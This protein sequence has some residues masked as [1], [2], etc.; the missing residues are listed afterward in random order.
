MPVSLSIIIPTYNER[1]N[2]ARLIESV[3]A[4]LKK[5]HLSHEIIIVDDNSPDGTAELIGSLK[6][7]YASLVLVRRSGK[8]G[9]SSA[10]MAGIAKARAPVVAVMDADF[11]HPPAL[12]PRMYDK[13]T[14]GC[15]FVI[16]SR[17][18]P[19]GK[20]VGWTF[21]RKLQSRV[22]TLLARFFT[23]VR[24]PVSGFFMIRK[25]VITGQKI[26][27]KG[28]KICLEILMR[29]NYYSTCELPMTF[30]NR[31]SGKSKAGTG[32]VFALLSNLWKYLKEGKLR[33]FKRSRVE[34]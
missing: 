18:I 4:I 14:E 27:A 31:K 32:E 22:A 23:P 21:Y 3:S 11:S 1:E 34:E 20:I 28:F 19:G 29:G 17:Y 10:V 7:K 26:D 6:K 24:D 33:F 12:L 30:V 16:G 25:R 8:L 2:I 13:I 9:L 5:D 15:D